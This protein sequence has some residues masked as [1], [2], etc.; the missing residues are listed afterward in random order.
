MRLEGEAGGHDMHN[1]M[2]N[3]IKFSEADNVHN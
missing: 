1:T 2:K 3:L